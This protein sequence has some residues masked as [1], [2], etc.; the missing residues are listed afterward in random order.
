M[1]LTNSSLLFGGLWALADTLVIL[2]GGFRLYMK[3]VRKLDHIEYAL[4]NDGNG[5]VQKV[6]ELHE[7]QQQIKTDIAVMK[8]KVAVRKTRSK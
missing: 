2:G 7:D 4:F 1:N 6:S 3:I 5:V 8:T